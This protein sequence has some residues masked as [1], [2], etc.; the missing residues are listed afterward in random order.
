MS[1]NCCFLNG[2]AAAIL[3]MVSEFEV[4]MRVILPA[5][6]VIIIFA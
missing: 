5:N 3:A 2:A 6:P 1:V 4:A